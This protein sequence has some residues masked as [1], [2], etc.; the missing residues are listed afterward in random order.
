MQKLSSKIVAII[1]S[2]LMICSIGGA[3]TSLIQNAHAQ[4]NLPTSAYITVDPNPCGVG[5]T[6][7]VVFWL[8]VPLLNSA[9][10]VG[11][12]VYVTAPDGTKTTLGPFLG[13]ETGGT[14]TTY[15]PQQTGTYTFYWQ[16]AGQQLTTPGYTNDYEEPSTSPTVTLTVTNTPAT[17]YPFTPLPTTYWQAPVNAENVQNWYAITGPW[18]GLGPEPFGAT[19]LYNGTCA[20]DSSGGDYNPYTTIPTTGHIL[21]TTPWCIGGIAGG[22]DVAAPSAGTESGHYWCTSQYEPKWAPVVIDGVM[23]STWFTT[24][25]GY[26]NGIRA[27]N[28]YTGQQL[29]IINT[30]NPLVCGMVTY[31]QTPNQYGYVGPYLWTTG[32]LPASV[33]GGT[34][35]NERGTEWN[36]YD[37]LTGNYVCSLVNGTGDSVGSGALYCDPNGNLMLLYDNQTAGTQMIYSAYGAPAQAVTTTGPS[38]CLFN[39]TQCMQQSGQWSVAYDHQ[40]LWNLGIKNEVQLP[41]TLTSIPSWGQNGIGS[42]T[43][44]LGGNGVSSE[45]GGGQT[46]GWWYD[47]G[48][49]IETLA[50]MWTD[51]NTETPYTRTSSAFGDGVMTDVN[52]ET[53]VING[54]SLWTGALLWTN[55]LT[56]T[57]GAPANPYDTFDI[58]TIVGNGVEFIYGFGGDMW[59]VSL[60]NGDILWYTN[61]TQLFGSPGLETPYGTWPLW[62]FGN[63]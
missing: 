49:N 60:T 37:A 59:A 53:D 50:L 13:D 7:A 52:Q 41:S 55:T 2:L 29:W 40:Y 25:T 31:F 42:D 54:Y 45:F 51:N 16:F 17:E 14:H 19:G 30:T 34:A 4:V 6:V 43:I 26:S 62:I 12:T 8:G 48:Y 46:K 32:T 22:S 20:Q 57:N 24:T 3:S 44:V 15:T 39:F 47:V 21:W 18:L 11:M 33:T 36:L 58:Y 5:Q 27:L 35:Y 23:Y 61:T 9:Y 63:V 28:L 1:V 38:L 10:V 56:G